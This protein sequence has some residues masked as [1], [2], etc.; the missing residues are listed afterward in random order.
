M[1]FP[2]RKVAYFTKILWKIVKRQGNKRFALY[3]LINYRQARKGIES[4]D[5]MH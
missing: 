4:I 3:Y 1:I 5:Q 2:L